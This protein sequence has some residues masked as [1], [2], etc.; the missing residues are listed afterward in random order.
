MR[1][2]VLTCVHDFNW[3]QVRPF[4]VSLRRSG[5]AGDVVAF[6][7][8]VDLSVVHGLEEFNVWGATL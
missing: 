8:N 2:V 7:N 6:C 4:I 1:N 3:A 5:Y